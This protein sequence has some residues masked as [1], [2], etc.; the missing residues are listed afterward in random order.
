[1]ECKASRV[2]GEG[3][4]GRRVVVVVVVVEEKEEEEVVCIQ[5]RAKKR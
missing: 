2:R 5:A 1:M 3:E 4:G